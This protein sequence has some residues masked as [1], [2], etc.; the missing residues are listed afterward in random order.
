M[1]RGRR[2]MEGKLCHIS[3]TLVFHNLDM[4]HSENSLGPNFSSQTT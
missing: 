2:D 1:S 4:N 3:A